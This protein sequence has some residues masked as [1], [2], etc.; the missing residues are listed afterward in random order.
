[1]GNTGRVFPV[2]TR[3]NP[4]SGTHLHFVTTRGYPNGRPFNPYTLYR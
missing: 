3:S 4:Y 2:P 1:M